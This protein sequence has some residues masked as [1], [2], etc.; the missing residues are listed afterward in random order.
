MVA[1][2]RGAGLRVSDEPAQPAQPALDGRS[3]PV[4]L[5]VLLG[6]LGRERAPRGGWRPGLRCPRTV[7]TVRRT[8]PHPSHA[9]P[10]SDGRMVAEPHGARLLFFR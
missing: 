8:E 7:R 4:L 6:G 10:L 5:L 3:R 2:R 1:G 9:H